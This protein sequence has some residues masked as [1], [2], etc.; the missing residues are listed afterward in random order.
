MDEEN[1]NTFDNLF[2]DWKDNDDSLPEEITVLDRFIE[3]D[4]YKAI[5]LEAECGDMDSLSLMEDFSEHLRSLVFHLENDSEKTRVDY[6][7]KTLCQLV[8]GYLD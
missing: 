1:D 7:L 5:C 2:G 4:V 3:S 8:K 6:E